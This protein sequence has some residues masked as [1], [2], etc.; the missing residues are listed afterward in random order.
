MEKNNPILKQLQDII[1]TKLEMSESPKT[2]AKKEQEMFCSVIEMWDETWS[3]GLKAYEESKINLEEY[4]ATFYEIIETL[5]VMAYGEFKTEIIS[6]WVYERYTLDGEL[7]VLVTEDD[8]EHEIKTPL[9][10]FKFI[11]KL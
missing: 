6:W 9:E 1:G 3:R 10:L 2:K 5:F 4:D 7:A 11:K 8:K